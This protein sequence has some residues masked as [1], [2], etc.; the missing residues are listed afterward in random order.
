MSDQ[1]IGAFLAGLMG[2][3]FVGFVAAV[4]IVAQIEKHPLLDC[5]DSN[6]RGCDRCAPPR[7][8]E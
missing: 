3:F 2:G 1:V 5:L 7:A 4:K 6:C 8:R